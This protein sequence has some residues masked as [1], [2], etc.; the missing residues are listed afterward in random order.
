MAN[1]ITLDNLKEKLAP[2][3]PNSENQLFAIVDMGRYV[4]LLIPYCRC[5]I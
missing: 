5:L 1:L 3:N 4:S 2:W